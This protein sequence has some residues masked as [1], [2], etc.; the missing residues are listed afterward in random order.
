MRQGKHDENRYDKNKM[1][2]FQ[3]KKK[4]PGATENVSASLLALY[5]SRKK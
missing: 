2:G 1:N 4:L 3:K 5:R